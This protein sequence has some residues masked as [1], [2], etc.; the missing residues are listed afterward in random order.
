MRRY[1]NQ[2]KRWGIGFRSVEVREIRGSKRGFRVL[3]KT[4]AFRTRSVLLC[5][6][7][8]FKPW[9][10]LGDGAPPVFGPAFARAREFSGRPVA[11]VGGGEAAVHQTLQLARHASV[12]HLFHRG[13]RLKAI[14]VLQ[15]RLRSA[16]NVRVHPKSELREG[17]GGRLRVLRG[18]GEDRTIS[19]EAVFALVGQTPE[20]SILGGAPRP[21]GVF[22][23]GDAR[24]GVPRQVA[25]ASGDGMRAAMECERYLRR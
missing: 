3:T 4:G 15:Q 8:R 2:A 17:S 23:A 21:E 19:V 11:V 22:V 13:E 25:A 1:W 5:T 16:A 6:G 20:L 14:G 12:V 10:T 18:G 7:A 24:R 9:R